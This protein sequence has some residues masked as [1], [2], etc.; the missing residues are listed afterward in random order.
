MRMNV[1]TTGPR[2]LT[3]LTIASWMARLITLFKSITLLRGNDNNL[4]Y[5]PHIQSECGGIFHTILSI[6]HNIVRDTDNVMLPKQ[7]GECLARLG[8]SLVSS[9]NSHGKISPFTRRK[10]VHYN[11]PLRLGH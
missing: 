5:I 1:V 2:T 10:L 11:P 4:Q 3:P 6:P 7:F 9:H 8:F